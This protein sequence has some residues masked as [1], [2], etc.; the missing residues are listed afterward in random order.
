V[1]KHRYSISDLIHRRPVD[2]RLPPATMNYEHHAHNYEHKKNAAEAARFA[3]ATVAGIG[4]ALRNFYT[5][6]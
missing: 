5:S 3:A 4:L 6:T 2:E 1:L